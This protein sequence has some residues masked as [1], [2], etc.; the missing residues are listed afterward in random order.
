MEIEK[1][2]DS[3]LTP[4]QVD[5]LVRLA[6]L[7]AEPA[8]VDDNGKHIWS[9]DPKIRA[10]QMIYEGRLGGPQAGSGR[11]KQPRIAEVIAEELREERRVKR[12]MKAIDRALKADAGARANLD[13]I[14]LSIDIERNE[15]KLQIEE[16]EHEGNVGDTREELVATL[17]ELVKNP[18]VA[19]TLGENEIEEI[20]EAEIVE[21]NKP[22]TRS[23]R[24]NGSAGSPEKNGNNGRDVGTNGRGRTSS[25]GSEVKNPLRKAALRRAANG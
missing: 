10:L 24:S 19:A 11:K 22:V 3:G 17:F 18:E 1:A 23:A 13:A 12:M 4:R 2:D 16:E 21:E 5:A 25:N 14:K 20:T 15:R 6:E 7:G 9:S 8:T